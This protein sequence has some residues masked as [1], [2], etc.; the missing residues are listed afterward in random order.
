[1]Q[2]KNYTPNA[3]FS[4]EIVERGKNNIPTLLIDV[5]DNTEVYSF[6]VVD[7]QM[8]V[9]LD[10]QVYGGHRI[11]LCELDPHIPILKKWQEQYPNALIV[12][13][14]TRIT[15]HCKRVAAFYAKLLSVGLRAKCIDMH[16]FDF[17]NVSIGKRLPKVDLSKVI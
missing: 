5:R 9:N 15:L 16:L 13:A 3:I 1:M 14:S 2:C 4:S 8:S 12:V 17:Y 7:P 11:A 6:Y 10:G